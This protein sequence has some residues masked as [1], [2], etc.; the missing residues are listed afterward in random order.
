[1]ALPRFRCREAERQPGSDDIAHAPPTH[2][3]EPIGAYFT[4]T[5]INGA[6]AGRASRSEGVILLDPHVLVWLTAEAK[7]I[8]Q[9]GELG[10]EIKELLRLTSKKSP[11]RSPSD[12]SL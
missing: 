6:G 7:K 9:A 10:S 8:V 2:L 12:P 4:P 3:C 1:M 5:R 11:C